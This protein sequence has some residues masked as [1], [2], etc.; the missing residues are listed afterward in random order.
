MIARLGRLL[1][2]AFAKTAPDPFVLAVLLTLATAALAF[3]FGS[4]P[5]ATPGTGRVSAIID[6]WRGPNGIWRFLA[7]GMQ[8]CLIL[9][10]GHALAE[11]RPVRAIVRGLA[12]APKS[13]GGAAAMIGIVAMGFGLMN[14]GL[15]LIVGALLARDVARALESRGV[16]AH[17][18]LLAAAGY[19]GM[20]VWHGGLSGSAPIYMTRAEQAAAVLPAETIA[21][22]G[23][24]AAIP[25]DRTVFSPLNLFVTG[26]VLLLVPALLMLLTP[27]QA[28]HVTPMPAEED[29]FED[30]P[31]P[32]RSLPDFLE[33]SP[34]IPWALA[35]L[36][37]WA[38]YRFGS[39]G[40]A[41]QPWWRAALSIGPNEINMAML[42]LGLVAH[43]SVRSYV[44]SAE[45]G[46][47]GC[48]G[49]ILQFP[50][51]AGIMGMLATS[52]LI[53]SFSDWMAATA[54]AHNLP[55]LTF[56][57][58]GLVNLFV[59]SGGG[60]WAIQGPIAL[61]AGQGLGVPPEKMVM[62]VAYGDQLTNMLQP[63]WA[64]PLLAI[65][66]VKAR[67]IVGYTAIL[68]LVAG[69]WMALGLLLF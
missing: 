33:R 46:A 56:V 39:T 20:L 60:Q 22:L 59:P 69:A 55:L 2:A 64:L 8:M 37:G 14:W 40:P 53:A 51:Y 50:L 19:A 26:G 5:D 57:S 6:A 11:S 49:I 52:G 18:P 34:V 68:M 48:A 47:R 30:P 9:V 1:S 25:L 32:I 62:A 44:G 66:G 12:G 3:F 23:D 27:R 7:F 43:G 36:I 31:L 13:A 41:G 4:F 58:A 63:F 28:S 67:D 54:T 65:T 29:L 61:G 15:G 10:T 38:L 24:S 42:A 21:Q 16:P 17:G 45:R 35:L